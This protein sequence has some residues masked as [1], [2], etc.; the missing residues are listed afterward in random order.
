MIRAASGILAATFVL[1]ATAACT[2]PASAPPAAAEEPAQAACDAEA[3]RWAVGETAGEEMVER[4]RREAGARTVRVL[5]PGMA[6]T[7]DFNPLRLNLV[8]DEGMRITEVRCG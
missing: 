4:T 6:A 5:P 1:S 8:T 3:V 2:G 7:M